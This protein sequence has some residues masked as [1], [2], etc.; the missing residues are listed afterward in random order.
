MRPLPPSLGTPAWLHGASAFTTVR[1]LG[2]RALLWPAHLARL[3]GTCA[4]LGLPEPSG[5]LPTL[6]GAQLL[7][8]TVTEEGSFFQTRPLSAPPP[9]PQ[10]VRVW[11]GSWQVHPQL[12]GH[13]TGN[14]LPYR[15]AGAEAAGAGCFEGWLSDGAGHLADGS[16]TSPLLDLGGELTVPA[17]GLPGVTRAH[18]APGA[19]T[20]P[21]ALDELRGLRRAWVAGSGTGLVPVAELRGPDWSLKLESEWRGQ[22]DDALRWPPPP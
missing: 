3:R 14:Y 21:V 15:Q 10:G 17:G 5:E 7:R 12:A 13:K 8:V 6:E 9:P 19:V 20:R 22:E 4:W 1:V 16:R 2:G 18:A 11:L